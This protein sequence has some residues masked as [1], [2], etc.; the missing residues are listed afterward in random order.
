MGVFAE[1]SRAIAMAALAFLVLNIGLASMMVLAAYGFDPATLGERGAL[2]DSGRANAGLLRLA[3]FVDLVGYL[4]LAPVVVWMHRR[5]SAIV[6]ENHRRLEL[7]GLLSAGGLGFILVGAIG[8]ALLGSVGAWLLE[9]PAADAAT[10][11]AARVQFGVLENAVFVGLWGTLELPLLSIWL[12]GVSWAVRAEG[13]LFSWTGAGAG[14]G[15]LAYGSRTGL[16]GDVPLPITGPLDVLIIGGVGLLPIWV[17]WLASRLW[18][19][20]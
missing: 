14:L 15:A 5:L 17:L 16:T 10:H 20:R 1:Q 6:A 19:G 18:R 9:A 11:A 4:A 12:F 13:R 8:A 2:M 7:P 3:A